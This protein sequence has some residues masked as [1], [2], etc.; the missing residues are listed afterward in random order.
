MSDTAVPASPERPRKRPT[1]DRRELE[2]HA[3]TLSRTIASLQGE[4][5]RVLIKI[6]MLTPPS[7][8]RG[9]GE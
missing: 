9:G 2:I 8:V 3:E 5:M 6:E 7:G 1:T 4:L